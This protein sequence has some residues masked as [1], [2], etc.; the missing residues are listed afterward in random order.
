MIER[1]DILI[2]GRPDLVNRNAFTPDIPM[3]GQGNE[4][5]SR[6]HASLSRTEK[7]GE[8]ILSDLDSTNGTKYQDDTEN[9]VPARESRVYKHTKVRFGKAE[10]TIAEIVK[11]YNRKN[12]PF[13]HPE[14]HKIIDPRF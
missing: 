11:Q 5:V 8:Y 6:R 12:P 14:T 3:T 10:V 1:K 4:T 2:I 7:S 9:W 13:I